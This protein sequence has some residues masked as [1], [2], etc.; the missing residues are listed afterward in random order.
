MQLDG[1]A[2]GA[3]NPCYIIAEI[4]QN[5]QGDLYHAVR[6]I[7]MAE[8]CGVDAVKLQAR[9]CIEEFSAE[10]LRQPYQH[11][12]SFGKTYKDHRDALDLTHQDFLA[13]RARH[14]YN[15]NGAELF[16]TVCALS[17][18]EQLEK[19]NWCSFY[20][21][22]SKDLGNLELIDAIA[23]TKKPVIISTGTARDLRD[24][25]IAYKTASAHTDVA[26]MHCVSEY[27]TPLKRVALSK[28]AKLKSIFQCPV[29]YSD[30]SAGVKAPAIAA[31]KYGA[32]LLEVHV[33]KNRAQPGTDHAA[34]LEEPGL[35]QLVEWVRTSEA[36]D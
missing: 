18:L 16:C 5:H 13:L 11:R 25:E 26:L 34:S 31:I 4:G 22:A 1:R 36:I 32:D 30:H 10:R 27:P 29:G 20:K 9:D 35:R 24:I 2:I 28:I 8:S 21:I 14:S 7:Q 33:T 12:N 6:L 15:E 23:S 17:R 19:D 3:G